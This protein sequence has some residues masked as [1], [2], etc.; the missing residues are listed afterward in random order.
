MKQAEN[1]AQEPLSGVHAVTVQ[2]PGGRVLV[3]SGYAETPVD[4]LACAELHGLEE[5]TGK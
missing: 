1:A 2:C 4:A 5:V 3:W